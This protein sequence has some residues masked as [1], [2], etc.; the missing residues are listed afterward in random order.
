MNRYQNDGSGFRWR[1]DSSGRQQI[2]SLGSVCEL[3]ING[4]NFYSQNRQMTP[5]GRTYVLRGR[6]SSYQ[7]TRR[8]QICS[9]L[10]FGG[11]CWPVNGGRAQANACAKASLVR[12]HA[13]ALCNRLCLRRHT[14]TER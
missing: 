7:V 13:A 8:V 9:C 11:A 10:C 4:G 2:S 3:K 6:A 12:I 5:D 1:I 14:P